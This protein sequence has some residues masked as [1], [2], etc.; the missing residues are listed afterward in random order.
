MT[1]SNPAAPMDPLWWLV[2][3]WIDGLGMG[4]APPVLLGPRHFERFNAR[5]HGQVIDFTRNHRRDNRIWSNSL[6]EKRELYVYLPPHY[7]PRKAY[8]LVIFLHGAAQDEAFF[9]Q[10]QVQNFDQAIAAGMLPPVIVAAP[11]GSYRGR[12]S[13]I[14]PATFFANSRLGRFEDW[15]MDDV[16]QF[17]HHNFSIRP[18]REAHALI[19]ISMGGTAAFSFAIKHKE[20]IKTAVGVHPLLNLRWVDCQGRYQAPFDP[21]C[22]GERTRLR[23]FEVLGRRRLFTLRFGD[24]YAPLFGHGVQGAQGLAT[25]N[26]LDLMERLDLR[27]GELD[28]MAAYGGR[29]EFNVAAQV[30]S[31]VYRA[32]ERGIAV[33]ITHDPHGTHNL[34]TGM[35]FLPDIMNWAATRVPR[36]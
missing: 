23:G 6:Q 2:V 22:W 26:P 27:P 35:K 25:I 19:G 16:W 4:Q 17:M 5:L 24:V 3:F 15:I 33:D 12:V 1:A 31:F 36:D 34:S 30:E 28:L 10:A 11:D 9:L 21:N 8:P 32:R 18:E 29:D 7:D 20:R 13:L 14:K